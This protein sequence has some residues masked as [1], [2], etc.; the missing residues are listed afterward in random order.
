MGYIDRHV[1]S[2]DPGQL[3]PNE[4]DSVFEELRLRPTFHTHGNAVLSIPEEKSDLVAR[5]TERF[6]D[7]LDIRKE[8]L[9]SP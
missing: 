9:P 5:L 4:V 2:Y 1:I 8:A 6:G 3:N 7:L